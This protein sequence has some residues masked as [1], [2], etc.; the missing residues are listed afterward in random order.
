M[1]AVH[2]FT[3]ALVSLTTRRLAVL[4]L[5]LRDAKTRTWAGRLSLGRTNLHVRICAGEVSV[6][7]AE[8]EIFWGSS[9]SSLPD[10]LRPATPEER[11]IAEAALA[12]IWP[13]VRRDLEGEGEAA[14]AT[15][16]AEV[17]ALAA[18]HPQIA[19]ALLSGWA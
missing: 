5:E 13:Q 19:D 4:H 3:R 14:R 7:G 10:A 9:K 17:S 18:A 11:A 2:T 12:W 15:A 8:V 16:F 1:N 6:E